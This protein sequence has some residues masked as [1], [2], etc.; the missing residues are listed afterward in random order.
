MNIQANNQAFEDHLSL[1]LPAIQ[2]WIKGDP[3]GY[4]A[5]LSD[6]A[7][8]FDP[9]TVSQVVGREAVIEHFQPIAGQFEI[10]SMEYSNLELQIIGDHRILSCNWNEFDNE[11]E[12]LNTWKSSEVWAQIDGRWQI[13]HAHWSISVGE[14]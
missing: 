9:R 13:I 3:M 10:P 12:P 8:Y 1:L 11:G 6:D 14:A 2:R 7:V 4:A 5:L